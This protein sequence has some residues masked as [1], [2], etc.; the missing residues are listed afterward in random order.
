M[1]RHPDSAQ[2]HGTATAR[3]ALGSARRDCFLDLFGRRFR[4]WHVEQP[5]TEREA[6]YAVAI[7][8]RASGSSAPRARESQF[9]GGRYVAKH[10]RSLAWLARQSN[11]WHESD[12]LRLEHRKLIPREARDHERA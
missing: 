11:R 1:R 10:R 2:H 5:A 4:R 12:R 3:A 6:R 9:E 7:G 8:Y